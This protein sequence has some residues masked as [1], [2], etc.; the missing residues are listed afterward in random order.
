MQVQGLRF[1]KDKFPTKTSVRHW[2]SEHKDKFK[3]LK[4]GKEMIDSEHPNEHRVRILP[5][6]DFDEKTYRTI[7]I[8]PKSDG[9]YA[10]V[11]TLKTETKTK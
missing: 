1:A 2:L 3:P 5:P 4:K 11:G 8:G 6:E 10:A 7:Y 9:I